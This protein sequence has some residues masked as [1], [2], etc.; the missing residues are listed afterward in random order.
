MLLSR[1]LACLM[2]SHRVCM[3][4][5]VMA[6]HD[7]CIH[8]IWLWHGRD[9][10]CCHISSRNRTNIPQWK[11]WLTVLVKCDQNMILCPS[12]NDTV[13]LKHIVWISPQKY[14]PCCLIR[15][16]AHPNSKR[17]HFRPFCP[18]SSVSKVRCGLRW[19]KRRTQTAF[20]YSYVVCSVCR[21]R[22]AFNILTI[23]NA[24]NLVDRNLEEKTGL[25]NGAWCR[26]TLA[27]L[28]AVHWR[29]HSTWSLYILVRYCFTSQP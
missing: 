8:A 27:H 15:E 13:H 18:S 1:V 7:L 4:S 14:K 12:L 28:P 19:R 26:T 11:H 24:S 17:G 21:K 9:Q 6:C 23:W 29:V 10:Q 3:V 20:M 16:L 22:R 2:V 5:L 25:S